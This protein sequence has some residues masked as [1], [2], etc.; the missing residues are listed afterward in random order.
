MRAFRRTQF[1][2]FSVL[3][4]IA[5]L[6]VPPA[7]AQSPNYTAAA[8][9]LDADFVRRLR[10]IGSAHR[11]GK[12]A[13]HLQ[14]TMALLTLMNDTS[15]RALLPE[16]DR[17][18]N[19]INSDGAAPYSS[20]SIELGFRLARLNHEVTQKQF[21]KLSKAVLL[22]ANNPPL[23]AQSRIFALLRNEPS[24]GYQQVDDNTARAISRLLFTEFGRS[25]VLSGQT[26]TD[27]ARTV[28]ML[29]D[30]K[31]SRVGEVPRTVVSRRLCTQFVDIVENAL[32]RGGQ[33]GVL[34]AIQG[35]LQFGTQM[36]MFDCM[37]GER[38]INQ[39]IESF[40]TYTA[41]IANQMSNRSG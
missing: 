30:C 28:A 33:A 12:P 23:A 24:T 9:R 39:M 15:I 37:D 31:T 14:E 6:G 32:G 5:I 40:E 17:L 7:I 22:P 13:R 38:G 25:Q 4:A 21:A 10:A 20:I 29:W 34:P 36:Q 19:A 35:D 18:I 41:C 8:R 11:A 27:T 26:P 16:T 3:A 2:V 1:V